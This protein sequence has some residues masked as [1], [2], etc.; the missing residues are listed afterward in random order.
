MNENV[1]ILERLSKCMNETPNEE[2]DSVMTA[3]AKIRVVL[4]L[5]PFLYFHVKEAQTAKGLWDKLKNMYYDSGFTRRMSLLR[6]LIS[7]RPENCQ[8]MKS[9]LNRLFETAQK[10]RRTGST[11][12]ETWLGSL[13]FEGLSE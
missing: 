7:L 13:L 9:Y 12:D 2:I 5:V 6:T 8:S 10:L 11:I 1:F 4:A 3:K